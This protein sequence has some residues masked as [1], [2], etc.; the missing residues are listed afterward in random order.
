MLH[1]RRI[2]A[3]GVAAFAALPCRPLWS[4][5]PGFTQTAEDLAAWLNSQP[6]GWDDTLYRQTLGAANQWKEGDAIVGVAA[7]DE[8]HRQFARKLL[9][10][11]P[12]SVIDEHPPYSDDLLTFILGPIDRKKQS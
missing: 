1:R 7:R 5:G 11:T 10:K 8:Q 9:E 3:A 4:A 12:L 2:L 6:G